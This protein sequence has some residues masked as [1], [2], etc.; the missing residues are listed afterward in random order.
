MAEVEIAK[1][2]GEGLS[3]EEEIVLYT[4]GCPK[5]IALEKEIKSKKIKYSRCEDLKIMMEKGIEYAPAL[6]IGSQ[7]LDAEGIEE[8]LEN[9]F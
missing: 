8:W 1:V 6:Q 2:A 7:I 3:G 9:N 5:C 4:I